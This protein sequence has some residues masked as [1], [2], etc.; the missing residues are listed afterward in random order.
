VLP[1]GSVGIG[2]A[3]PGD[4]MLYVKTTKGPG[5]AMFSNNNDD[6]SG[7]VIS[8]Q[9][10]RAGSA[11]AANDFCG[12]ITFY[13]QDTV[14]AVQ[15]Y[16]KISTKIGTPT[17][18]S[19]DG[20][21]LFE[22]TTAGTTATPY[23]RL[24]GATNAITASVD[25]YVLGAL[26]Q[27]GSN[28][29]KYVNKSTNYTLTN[30]DSIVYIGHD[31]NILTASLPDAE[32]VDG[33]VYTIKNTSPSLVVIKPNGAQLIDGLG[34]ITGSIGQSWTLASAGDVW[35]VLSSHSSSV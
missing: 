33:I 22:V 12:G 3:V 32:T 25:T 15:Q 10:D 8:L 5:I 7:A 24:D 2:G 19:E 30:A 6:A 17:S 11:G 26:H 29:R 14:P 23:L 16:A 31:T 1:S 27:S 28:Y 9:N 35:N 21:M 34:S 20:Y 18:T 4:Q 13:G